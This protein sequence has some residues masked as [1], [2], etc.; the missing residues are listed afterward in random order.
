MYKYVNDLL[1]VTFMNKF[2]LVSDVHS[3][4][5]RTAGHFIEPTAMTQSFKTS[6]QYKG[7]KLW[8]V[9]PLLLKQS[10]SLKVFKYDVK[11]YFI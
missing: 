8:N 2:I 4:N 3:Y 6:M 7:P 9:L 10:T 1:P 11:Q 5:T